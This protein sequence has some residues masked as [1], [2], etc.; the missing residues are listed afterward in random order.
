MSFF[1]CLFLIYAFEPL[2]WPGIL[3]IIFLKNSFE[4]FG[5]MAVSKSLCA[6]GTKPGRYIYKFYK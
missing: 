6:C 5:I 4:D 1:T 3:E 2:N